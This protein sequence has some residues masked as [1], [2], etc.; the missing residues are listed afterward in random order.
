[1]RVLRRLL[2]LLVLAVAAV[3]AAVVVR[4]RVS[5]PRERVELYYDDGSMTSLEAGTPDA[6]RLLAFAR[7]ALSAARASA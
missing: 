7:E 5:S 1:V 4:R 3:G 6:E 2:G